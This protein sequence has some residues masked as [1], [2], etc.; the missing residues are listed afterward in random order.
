MEQRLAQNCKF[1]DVCEVKVYI[2]VSFSEQQDESVK[3]E[4][5]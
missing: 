1:Y 3:L 5:V 4:E 2:A